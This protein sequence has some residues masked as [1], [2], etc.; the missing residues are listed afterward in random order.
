MMA[1]VGNFF[2][3]PLYCVTTVRHSNTYPHYH[4]EEDYVD[5]EDEDGGHLV[6]PIKGMRNHPGT[7]T[8]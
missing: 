1:C 2:T 3:A 8:G 5:A 7:M 6:E 4:K